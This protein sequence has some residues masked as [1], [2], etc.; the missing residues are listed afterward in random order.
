MAA[1]HWPRDVIAI[2][3]PE[4]AGQYIQILRGKHAR[5]A[6]ERTSD[7]ASAAQRRTEDVNIS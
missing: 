1:F 2:V 5:V 7:L 6:S 4:F 3:L